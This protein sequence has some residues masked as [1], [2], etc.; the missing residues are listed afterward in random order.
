MQE[1]TI[2]I[3][4]GINSKVLIGWLYFKD[5]N[6]Q[7]KNTDLWQEIERLSQSYRQEFPDT[8]AAL[9]KLR[10]ARTLYRAF[11]QE[12]TRIRPSSEALFR[13]II[14]KKP[15]Y[16]INSIV[17]VCNY[18]SL[19]FFLPIGLYDTAKIRGAINIRAGMP[20][21]EYQGIGKDMIHVGNRLTLADDLGPFGNP[22]A[23]SRRTAITLESQSV[24]MVLFAPHKYPEEKLHAHLDFAKDVMLRYHN[25]GKILQQEILTKAPQGSEPLGDLD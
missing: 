12:P 8:S 3:E 10:P 18:C 9:N 16:Q 20:G 24:L 19:K 13:R 7:D 14:R 21:E 6:C 15:L 1:P 25:K 11:G 5:L 4:P 22:S 17:D 23:D 2:N